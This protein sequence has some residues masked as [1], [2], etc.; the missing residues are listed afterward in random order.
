MELFE[1]VDPSEAKGNTVT[2]REIL[3][4]GAER[5]SFKVLRDMEIQAGPALGKA[6]GAGASRP[7]LCHSML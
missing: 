3:D 6:I 4:R 2:A 5:K 1:V 7:F